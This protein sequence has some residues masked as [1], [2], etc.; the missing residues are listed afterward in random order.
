MAEHTLREIKRQ[1]TARSLARTTYDLV[2][3]RGLDRVTVEEIT[4]AL[5]LSRR[6]FSNYYGSKEE[7]VASVLVHTVSDGLRAWQ[8]PPGADLMTGV[9]ALVRHQFAEGLLDVFASFRRL[10]DEHPQ[11]VPYSNDALWRMW[12][13]TGEHLRRTL[14]PGEGSDDVG[15][16]MVMGAIY[17]V[18]SRHLTVDAGPASA[19]SSA[20]GRTLVE[21]LAQVF[22]RLEVALGP[23]G[24]RAVQA[25]PGP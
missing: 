3:E 7:A 11:L 25:A 8:P 24:D 22:A 10:C 18:V 2:L 9:R 5:Q 1:A 16:T 12:E 13:L 4:S 14:G 21:D 15:L 19:A 6:T 17:G 20:R 23:A